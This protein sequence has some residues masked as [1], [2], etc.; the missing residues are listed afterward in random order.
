MNSKMPRAL[1][2]ILPRGS[3]DPRDF[4]WI[5]R[6]RNVRKRVLR[7]QHNECQECKKRGKLTRATLVHH[8]LPLREYPEYALTPTLPSGEPQL[9]ALC[10]EC[11]E[12][13]ETERGNR[14]TAQPLTDEWW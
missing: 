9:I 5:R 6:W 10:F 3:D 12:R 4:Y 2:D 7:E 1:E 11:H 8:H 14:G 13:I